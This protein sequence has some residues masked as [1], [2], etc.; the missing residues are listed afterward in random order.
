VSQVHVW[1]SGCR[2]QF[3]APPAESLQG[4]PFAEEA[5]LQVHEVDE[6][7]TQATEHEPPDDMPPP[8]VLDEAGVP[9]EALEHDAVINVAS[10]TSGAPR[11]STVERIISSSSAEW[12][13]RR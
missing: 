3:H 4:A 9:S 1:V 8:S 10:R 2:Q 6:L 5:T 13:A 11:R 7:A 12:P